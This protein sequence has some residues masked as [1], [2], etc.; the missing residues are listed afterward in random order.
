MAKG[1]ASTK[2][3]REQGLWQRSLAT[4]PD[5]ML[6][7]FGHNDE[8]SP[9][10]LERQVTMAQYEQNLRNFVTEAR[11]AGIKPVL[12]TPLTRRYF[13]SDGKI[14]SDLLKHSTT[15]KRVATDMHVPLIDLQDESIA[16]LNHIG[17]AQALTLGITK[18][19]AQGNTVPDKT[20]LDWK[21]S[22]I[23]GR[24]V[25]VDLGKAVPALAQYVKPAPATLPPQGELAMRVIQG[26]PFKIVL[27]GDST[28]AVGGG[29]GPGF[30]ATLTP[31][32]TCVDLAAN[33]RSSKSY[34]E[35]GLWKKALDEKGQYYFFQFGHNDQKSDPA[36]HTDPDTTY[37]ENLHRYIR[38]TRA[39]GA[40]PILVTPLSRRNYRDGQLVIDPLANYAAA[41]RRVAAQDKV[42]LVDLYAMSTKLLRGMTQEQADVL[43]ATYHPD[44]VAENGSGA[45][46]DRTH[47]NEKGKALFGRMVADNVAREEVE[48]G[49]NIKGVSTAAAA[50]PVA[51]N[52]HTP[53]QATVSSNGQADFRTVQE[54]IDQAPV[55]GEIIR[56][57]PGTYR[58]KLHINKPNIYL[59]GLGTHPQDVILSWDDAASNAGGTSKSGTVTVDA[60]GF[61]AENLTI[62]NTWELEHQRREEG[63]QAVALLL[64]SDH[65]VLDHVRLLSA[66]D[67]LYANSRTCRSLGE[68]APC[69]ASREYFRDCYI[70]GHVD[71]IFGDA[72]AVFDHCELHSRHHATVMLTAQSK[73][74]PAE[75]SGYYFLHCRIT[76][77]N[78]GE[79]VVLGR[80]WREYSTVL[81]YDTDIEQTIAPEGWSDWNGRLSTST[82]REYRSHGP[83][84]DGGHRIVSYPK[85]TRAAKR[86][87]TP[88]VLLRGND[89]WNPTAQA[90]ALR[91]MTH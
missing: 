89:G 82:Y 38:E 51:P 80:P 8:E 78:E 73:H 56:I 26:A 63:S 69:Q 40:I 57:M 74:F 15:M 75:D 42:T 18:K 14:H 61:E 44:A 81:F 9:E 49:P 62:E 27:V 29:W 25:A 43:D 53:S 79:K 11:A 71:Y 72:K 31:N 23:F 54:A 36:R 1:G 87:L 32:V 34:I 91:K 46:P 66:Q 59:V 10:H 13:G 88:D 90:N 19:D 24:M 22:Y 52:E 45:K 83:G 33:G 76:G 58:E 28:V 12:V 60:D 77:A 35:E 70:E 5:Y 41:A 37:A 4:K 55:A 65:A 6:I 3:F 85:L 20:H 39:I 17:E 30:C 84:V 68:T 16:Y 50:S 21:G 67:T 7:Q 86:E 64:S 2:T 47:L 48:L